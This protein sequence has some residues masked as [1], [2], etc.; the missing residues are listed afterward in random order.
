M[1]TMKKIEIKALLEMLDY[2]PETGVLVWKKR[3]L[4]HFN[5]E[6]AMIVFNSTRAGRV[7][8]S[9]HRAGYRKIKTLDGGDYLAHRVAWAMHSGSWP[10]FQIDHKNGIR[11]D[12]RIA[13][14][15]IAS[16]AD[17]C[18]NIKIPKTNKSGVIGVSAMSNQKGWRARIKVNSKTIHLGKF[19]DFDKA[20]A[21]RKAAEK[22][23]HKEFAGS[24]R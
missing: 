12:N 2:D 21:A 3:P 19:D 14:L 5:S 4:E 15:R 8:G 9:W 18:R 1:K 7:A 6:R 22:L 10:Q 17:N 23:H 20:V 16:H 13:N 11:H 24:N